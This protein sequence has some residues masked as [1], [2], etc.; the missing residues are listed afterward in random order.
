MSGVVNLGVGKVKN[1]NQHKRE[2]GNTNG[3]TRQS[4]NHFQRAVG[5]TRSA[6]LNGL[7]NIDCFMLLI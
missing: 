1:R 4:A 2:W 3:T 5:K 7:A 6:A